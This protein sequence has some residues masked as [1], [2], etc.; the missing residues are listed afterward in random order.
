MVWPSAIYNNNSISTGG[1][2][3]SSSQN[4][5]ALALIKYRENPYTPQELG[6]AASSSKGTLVITS[7]EFKM[8]KVFR[9]SIAFDKRIG[10]G[11]SFSLENMFT[12]NI[13]DI[14]YTNVNLLPPSLKM[15]T[16]PD[17]RSVYPNSNTIIMRPNTT[18]ST[19]SAIYLLTNA[20]GKKGFSYNFTV[21]VNKT[22]KTGFNLNANYNYGVSQVLNEA[23]SSTPGSQWSSMETVNGRNY[24]TVSESDN[25]AGHRIFAYASQKF[26]YLNK[27][28]STTISLSYT[29][30]SG[31][32]FSYVYNGQAVKDGINFQDLIYIPTA[33]ELQAMTFITSGAV[34]ATAD[35]QKAAFESFI[36]NDKY[37]SKH[38]GGYAERNSNRT[39]FT[40]VI[41]MKITQAF[42]LKFGDRTYSAE[43]GYSMFNFTN[44]LNRDWGRQYV[45]NNDNY[46]LLSFSYAS[47]SN[48]TPRYT[49][50]PTTPTAPTVYQR[51]NPSYT[52]RWLSQW[53]VRIKF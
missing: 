41:D 9:T 51:F 3:A 40:H 7:K 22:T 34:T 32:P 4:A 21:T 43:V 15:A 16:G 42:N 23:Q 26:G 2:S 47:T 6:I 28:M 33:S 25:S 17:T 45:V 30:Q 48:L 12:K 13:N 11:W 18:S 27:K 38:R 39:P 20:T 37:L 8:P 1:F 10:S 53:E 24:L 29:G 49:F 36:Q 52:A 44:F 5:A 46:S 31:A 19:Y 35:Q 14:S 50:N